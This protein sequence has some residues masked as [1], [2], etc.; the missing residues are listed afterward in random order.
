MLITTYRAI[1]NRTQTSSLKINPNSNQTNK[2]NLIE[3]TKI[4][5]NTE[6]ITNFLAALDSTINWIIPFFLTN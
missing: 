5:S 3:R 2:K 6:Q 4:E 1:T